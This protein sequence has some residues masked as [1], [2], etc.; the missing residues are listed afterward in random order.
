MDREPMNPRTKD[1]QENT[2]NKMMNM[3]NIDN[4]NNRVVK[5]NEDLRI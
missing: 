1:K 3:N 5:D 2:S 4:T